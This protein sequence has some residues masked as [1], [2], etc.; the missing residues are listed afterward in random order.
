MRASIKP[1]AAIGPA[2][3]L[4]INISFLA[5]ILA[6]VGSGEVAPANKTEWNSGLSGSIG[7]VF[8]RKPIDAYKQVLARPA[9]FKSREPF[10]P[11]PPP[12]PAA[13]TAVPPSGVVDPNLVLGGVMIQNDMRKVYLFSRANTAGAWISEG[14]E[15]LGWQIRS[16]DGTSAKLEQK[17]R[18]IDLQLYPKD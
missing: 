15:F 8:S 16:I 14:E 7:S 3:A 1:Q 12:A 11:A 18:H 10:V 6:S 4:A 5:A 17:G 13:R 2:I 9:F